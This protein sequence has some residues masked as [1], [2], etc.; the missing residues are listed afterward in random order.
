M[1]SLNL[2]VGGPITGRVYTLGR[3]LKTEH[4][5]CLQFDGPITGD[6]YGGGGGGL[7]PGFYGTIT[8]S[9]REISVLLI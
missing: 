3:G 8:E 4:F 6:S 7:Q 5:F 9:A 1:E 2:Q